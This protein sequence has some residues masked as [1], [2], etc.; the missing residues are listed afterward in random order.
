MES[1]PS[2]IDPSSGAA[3]S[4]R[5]AAWRAGLGWLTCVALAALAYRD[6][7]WVQ[8]EQALSKEL[9]RWFFVPSSS[10]APVVVLLSLWLL[11]RRLPTLRALPPLGGS[12]PTGSALL[13]A[14]VASYL[15][16]T[17]TSA[18]DLLVPSLM[19]NLLACAWLWRGAAGLRA[20][21]LPVLFLVF[22]MPLPPPALSQLV[23]RLQLG[24]TEVAGSL[25]YALGVPHVVSGE[26]IVRPENTFSV[27]ETCSG[28]RSME[29][30]TIVSILMMD[31]FRRRGLHAW[32]IVL[33]AP[34]VAF[35]L[36]GV[37]AVLLILNP[38]S[39]IATIHNLQGVAILLGG[40]LLL[41]ALDG[42]LEW[43]GRRR[44]PRPRARVS[45]PAPV[46]PWGA[47]PAAPAVAG[48]LAACLAASL[49]LP[50]WEVPDQPALNLRSRFSR[51]LGGSLRTA[52]LET[53]RLFLGSAS[54]RESFTLRYSP[55]EGDPVVLFF[56]LGW[57]PDRGRGLS[58]K[59]RLPGSGWIVEEEFPV[60]LEP[61]ARAAHAMVL[62]SGSQRV[63]SY[64]WTEGALAWPLEAL[65]GLLALDRSPL[66]RSEEVRVVRIG[67][68]IVGPLPAGK[69][70]AQETLVSFYHLLQPL[71]DGLEADLAAPEKNFS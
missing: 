13:A 65:R 69:K 28:L 31:L 49:W 66:R 54:F 61:G 1:A 52:E 70:A 43:G 19:L 62:R 24:T 16:A 41:F 39:E 60:T 29:T 63:L 34:P 20:V 50:R 21:L 33:A 56:G 14:G 4:G 8:P 23:F 48:A 47:L 42:L 71:L 27:I 9:E 57:R 55:H 64:H 59:T 25:L 11:Y 18:A 15:W 35:L 44:S 37:R 17:Y 6:L 67:T 32:L 26:R 12:R 68:A 45:E 46:R 40:V 30:L 51:G 3:A 53:D 5:A 2:E 10:M 36:N 22:A 38:H 7:L 58:P